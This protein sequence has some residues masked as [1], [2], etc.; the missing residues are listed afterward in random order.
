M[1][2]IRGSLLFIAVFFLFLSIL[3][4]IIFL[5]LSLSLS[6]ENVKPELI[7]IIEDL[8]ESE[9]GLDVSSVIN[10]KFDFMQDYCKNES[11]YIFSHQKKTFVIPCEI[12]DQGVGA[13]IEHELG[14]F[15]EEIYYKEYE[16]G[17]WKCLSEPEN[18]LVLVSAKA[19]DYWYSKFIFLL[20]AS[21]ALIVLIFFLV[22]HRANILIIVGVIF[23]INSIIFR[24]LDSL[25]NF[26][27]GKPF[28]EFSG[29]FFSQEYIVFLSAIVIGVVLV[30]IGVGLRFISSDFIKNKFLK[31]EEKISKKEVKEIIKEEISK[32][33]EKVKEKKFKEKDKKEIKEKKNKTKKP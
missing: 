14:D 2:F 19:R 9:T 22:K 6:Y 33:K 21:L 13:I 12:V 28:S 24:K 15:S 32:T 18:S 31:K 29:I 25:I 8:S 27:V 20:V 4:G 7:G 1:G 5:T 16:C 17:F 3:T 26:L 30:V 10:E 23:I 11:D